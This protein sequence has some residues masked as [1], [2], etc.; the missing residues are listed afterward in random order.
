M[1]RFCQDNGVEE[2][3][4]PSIQKFGREMWDKLNFTRKKAAC[5]QTYKVYGVT[6]ADLKESIII[7]DLSPLGEEDSPEPDEFIKDDD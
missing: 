4:I 3:G 1:V 6:S 5:G 2:K 7:N